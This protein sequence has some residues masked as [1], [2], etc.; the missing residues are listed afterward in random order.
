VIALLGNFEVAPRVRAEA[1]VGE[2][3]A[4]ERHP[5]RRERPWTIA[6]RIKLL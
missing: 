1:S 4:L 6:V 3:P 5:M 2:Q